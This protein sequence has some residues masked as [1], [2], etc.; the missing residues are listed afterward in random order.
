M[1]MELRVCKQ[2]H[3][4]EHGNERK[5][6]ITQDMVACAEQIRE[7]K[8]IIGLDAV[9]ITKVEAGDAG[10]AE[11]LDVIVA[12]IQDDTVTLQ[13]TQLVIEDNDESILVYPDHDDIIEVL[14]RN[15]DQISEQTRQDV[16][17]EL[18]AETAELIT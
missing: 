12:G 10:G 15:L 2:C 18:S 13:D 9:Y 6:A 14:T 1:Q 17:V 16:S 3:T 4:G 11:A 8:D 7:Y 5:T